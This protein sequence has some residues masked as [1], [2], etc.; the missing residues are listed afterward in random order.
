MWVMN[1]LTGSTAHPAALVR[2][3]HTPQ[4]LLGQRLGR[5]HYFSP[6]IS[7]H[8]Y[9]EKSLKTIK[10]FQF[11]AAGAQSAYARKNRVPKSIRRPASRHGKR[12]VGLLWHAPTRLLS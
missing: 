4:T 3:Q 1:K 6:K 7:F 5:F 2:E 10:K 8:Y 12:R 9:H 11:S